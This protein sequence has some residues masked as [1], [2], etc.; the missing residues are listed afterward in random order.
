MELFR[1][2]VDSSLFH[3]DNGFNILAS[4]RSNGGPATG[5]RS[6]NASVDLEAIDDHIIPMFSRL[7]VVC[8][9]VGKMTP[10]MHIPTAT[11]D[12]P[13]NDL[14]D[15]RQRMFEVLD[16]CIRFIYDTT[17]KADIFQVEM[18]DFV[19]QVK[20][21]TRLDAWR[22]QLDALLERM[23]VASKPM[24]QDSVN[25]LLMHYKVVYIWV[26]VCTVAG[27]TATDAFHADFEELIHYAEQISKADVG[28]A[29]PEP[30][31][32]DVST[33]GPLYYA[34]LKCR[35]PATRRRALELLR[36][37]PRREG[38]WNSH[39]AYATA[40]RIIEVEERHVNG[41]GLPA[42]ASRVHGLP[43]PDDGSRIYK[44]GE[45]PFDPLKFVTSPNYPGTLEIVFRTKPWGLLGEWH[46]VKE[47]IT[48]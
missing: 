44:M 25:V 8:S 32:F 31:S 20:L 9:L 13:H 37:A 2:N 3:V 40:K 14:T 6:Q 10:P 39:H 24:M 43:L 34:T 26:R 41:R 11:Q 1:G 48:V 36:F 33:M 7:N 17:P 15:S 19:E 22:H 12:S 45:T 46:E 42:E 47:H 5:R 18:D 23:R 21:Q 16:A 28:T 29:T 4:I 27:E 35:C 38:V 30:L